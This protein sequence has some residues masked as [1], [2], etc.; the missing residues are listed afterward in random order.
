MAE[1]VEFSRTGERKKF[2]RAER[3]IQLKLA[4]RLQQMPLLLA[5]SRGHEAVVKLLLGQ[6]DT[7]INPRDRH[8]R[9]PLSLA[10]ERGSE[11]AIELLK[12]H[13]AEP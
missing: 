9:T 10:I 4:D 1:L 2:L 3:C 11:A 6:D 7:E 8:G 5:A 12:L 13:G